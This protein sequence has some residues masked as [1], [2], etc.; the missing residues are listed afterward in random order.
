MAEPF[1]GNGVLRDCTRTF[2]QLEKPSNRIECAKDGA[3]GMGAEYGDLMRRAAVAP[4]NGYV[5]ASHAV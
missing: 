4:A 2:Y 5:R 1:C 3:N